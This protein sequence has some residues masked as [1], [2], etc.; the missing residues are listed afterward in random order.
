LRYL[1]NRDRMADVSLAQSIEQCEEQPMGRRFVQL[2]GFVILF[3]GAIHA[4]DIAATWQG[5]LHADGEDRRLWCKWQ[6]RRG[7]WTAPACFIDFLHDPV[8]IDSLVVQGQSL[9]LKVN[10]GKGIFEGPLARMETP[11]LE[12]GRGTRRIRGLELRRATRSRPGGRPSV[13]STTCGM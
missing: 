5:N 13:T 12:P 7:A 4:Q 10:G 11:S 8:H 6:R 3:A 1:R 9:Q 2:S